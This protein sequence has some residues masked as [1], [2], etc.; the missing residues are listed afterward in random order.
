[1]EAMPNAALKLEMRELD[2]VHVRLSRAEAYALLER[3]VKSSDGDD[4]LM[5]AAIVKLARS[6]ESSA[7]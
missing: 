4:P 3:V 1:M 6:I 7:D 5:E 2:E